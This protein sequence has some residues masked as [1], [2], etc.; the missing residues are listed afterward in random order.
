M[1]THGFDILE[2]GATFSVC[3]KWRYDLWRIWDYDSPPCAFIGLNPSTADEKEDDPTVRR[4]MRFSRS[5]GYGGLIML[6]LFG[7]RATDPAE[8]KRQKDPVGIDNDR[9]ILQRILEC[10]LTVAA[11]G[12]HGSHLGRDKSFLDWIS[13]IRLDC[14]GKTKAGHPKHPLYLSR[15]LRPRL[16][17]C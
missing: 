11:W 15:E 7:Y 2:H 9:I 13:G 3:K 8:M 17:K 5:W 12:N 4:C 10:P 16:F 14:L 6:N 1:A